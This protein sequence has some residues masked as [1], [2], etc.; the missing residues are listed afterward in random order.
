MKKELLFL[1][2][3]L[4]FTVLSN[5]QTVRFDLSQYIELASDSSLQAFRAKNMY[6]TSYWDYRTYKTSFLPSVSFNI[7]PLQY[8]RSIT[9]RYDYDKNLDVFREQQSLSYSGGIS[10]SQ[11]IPFVDGT[12]SINSSLSY[13]NNSAMNNY[14]QYSS[15][16]FRISYTQTLFGFN[17]SKWERR[18]EPLK[19][20]QAKKRLV[21][22]LE[23]ISETATQHFF[24]LV[25]AQKEYELSEN[26]AFA[27]DTLF[28]VGIERDKISAISKSDLQILELNLINA[29]NDLKNRKL[30]LKNAQYMFCSFLNLSEYLIP[31][32]IVPN[33]SLIG[34]V[35][36]EEAIARAVANNPEYQNFS[37][38]LL[39]AEK[40]LEQLEKNSILNANISASIGFNQ[41]A[42]T[43]IG[44][45]KDPLQQDV[46]SIGLSIPIVD[47][48]IKKG[49]INVAKNN[50][51][52]VRISIE[53]ERK[54]LEQEVIATIDNFNLLQELTIS[55]E[56]ALLLATSA[57]EDTKRRF[58]IGKSDVNSLTLAL[59][60]QRESHLNYL[61][62][63][64]NYWGSYYKLRRLT[65]FDFEKQKDLAE[66]IE[67]ELIRELHL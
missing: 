23:E 29:K 51:N 18:I 5:A 67:N 25:L 35:S 53:K 12:F 6:L 41:A 14:S 58:I 3:Y 15:V 52:L 32:I 56:K 17:N 49:R 33:K 50:L 40:T 34:I 4:F 1:A 46:V 26:N 64:K 36:E 60:R 44:A 65:L 11:K 7:T 27:A 42:E 8:N 47:W 21:Y 9:S 10:V 63:L 37:Q 22:Q 62:S 30:H 59:N 13:L 28:R 2:F 61:N 39:E 43:F 19:F 66:L 54:D 45:Y 20:E 55:L 24:N 16:P 31:E 57:Y 38:Q 48:G